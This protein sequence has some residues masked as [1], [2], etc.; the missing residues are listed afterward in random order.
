MNLLS[1]GMFDKNGCSYKSEG[2]K[3]RVLKGSLVVLNGSLQHGLY[4]L[5]GKAIDGVAAAVKEEDQTRL[6]HRR[7]GHISLRGLQE[8]CKQGILDPKTITS[9]ELCESSVLGKTHKL[10]FAKA[11]HMSNCILEYLHAD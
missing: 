5:E 6:C 3:L 4:I 8:L 9:L 10:K 1:L 2:G 7:L 11:S